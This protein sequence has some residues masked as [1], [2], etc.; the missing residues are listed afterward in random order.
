MGVPG[1]FRGVSFDS[2][3]YTGCEFRARLP[4]FFFF[5]CFF[6]SLFLILLYER[7]VLLTSIFLD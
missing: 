3:G 4:F 1:P 5:L 6:V 2:E 7:Y